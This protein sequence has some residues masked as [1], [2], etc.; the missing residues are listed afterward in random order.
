MK[1]STARGDKK[2]MEADTTAGLENRD[3]GYLDDNIGFE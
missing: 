2:K 1:S 3:R